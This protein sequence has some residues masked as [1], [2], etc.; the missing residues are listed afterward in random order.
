MKNLTMKKALL[1]L[2]ILAVV[3]IAF[4]G[5]MHHSPSFNK[6]GIV[7]PLTNGQNKTPNKKIIGTKK[8]QKYDVN[9]LEIINVS[10]ELEGIERNGVRISGLKNKE[11]ENQINSE[12]ESAEIEIKDLMINS[13]Y[14]TDSSQIT[15]YVM[16]NYSNILSVNVSGYSYINNTNYTED[17]YLN[18][19]L[20]TGKKLKLEDLFVP[21]VDIDMYAQNKIYKDVLYDYFSSANI[22]FNPEYWDEETG[23][24][25]YFVNNLDE[26]GELRIINE[27]NL[28]KNA[29]KD[30]YFNPTSLTINY[31][32][33]KYIYLEFEDC[34]DDLVIFNKYVTKDSIFEKELATS[35]KDL[36]VCST[37]GVYGED[38]Y[39]YVKDVAPNFRMDVRR[40]SWASKSAIESQKYKDLINDLNEELEQVKKDLL[41]KANN[42]PD[43][44]YYFT[45]ASESY[46]NT[47]EGHS[48]E[49]H[50]PSFSMWYRKV[51]YEVSKEDFENWFEDKM[52]E[53]YTRTSMGEIASYSYLDL[54]DEEIEKANM[55]EESVSENYDFSDEAKG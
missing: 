7:S 53:A 14:L 15:G 9:D 36:Y 5:H 22:F 49:E 21:G 51:S 27:Y 42:N 45:Y 6:N 38:T 18:Y 8:N 16:A 52:I 12:I 50:Y 1:I 19:D 44:Y 29:K 39:F 31:G 32:E 2:L 24:L 17:I 13:G 4:C 33:N 43:K 10:G 30:F 20:T 41:E 23:R 26:E 11:I 46:D 25:N 55:I 54:T 3:A 40:L 34:L 35:A 48:W 28:Y 47:P 37:V